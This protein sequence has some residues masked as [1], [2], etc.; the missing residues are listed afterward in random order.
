MTIFEEIWNDEYKKQDN[1]YKA[2]GFLLGYTGKECINCGRNR[3]EKYSTGVEI[4]EKC[5]TDQKTKLM[6]ENKYG[7]YIEYE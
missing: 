6:Y 4:C 7:S 2:K 1:Y 3:V 5:G